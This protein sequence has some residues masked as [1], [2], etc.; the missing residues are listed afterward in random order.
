MKA[1]KS[2]LLISE[3]V[4]VVLIVLAG[5]GLWWWTQHVSSFPAHESDAYLA[6]AESAYQELVA[7]EKA[8]EADA[9]YHEA[10]AFINLL[11]DEKRIPD[12]VHSLYLNKYQQAYFPLAIEN[13]FTLLESETLS[14]EDLQKMQVLLVEL[15][16]WECSE[17]DAEWVASFRKKVEEKEKY[18]ALYAA[19]ELLRK[20]ARYTT[21]EEAIA[22]I[23]AINECLQNPLVKKSEYNASL[24]QVIKA[25]ED[26]HLKQ[27][28]K[29]VNKFKR[30]NFRYW[31]K[32]EYTQHYYQDAKDALA[33]YE[34]MKPHYGKQYNKKKIAALKNSARQRYNQAS[35]YYRKNR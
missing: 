13:G 7:L 35:S 34:K 26:D 14:Y 25:L 24:R 18:S 30:V 17:K 19:A 16:K 5:G 6:E 27:V 3:L 8:S 29:A 11:E 32:S 20:P 2:T 23:K 28:E 12:S 15:N 33:S 9:V 31:K 1:T 10:T 22:H 4:L 21:N